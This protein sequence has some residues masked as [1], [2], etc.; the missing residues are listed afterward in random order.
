[1][2]GSA[3]QQVLPVAGSVETGLQHELA[4]VRVGGSWTPDI[5]EATWA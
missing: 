2:A 3:A 4:P 5:L 1:V